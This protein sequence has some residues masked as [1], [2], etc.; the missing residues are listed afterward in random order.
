[1]AL[2][3]AVTLDSNTITNNICRTTTPEP[4]E[5]REP[6]EDREPIEEEPIDGPETTE[7]PEPIEEPEANVEPEPID[8]PETTVTP[9]PV[10]T[11]DTTYVAVTL[12]PTGSTAMT[13]VSGMGAVLALA[14]FALFNKKK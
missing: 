8:E 4:I 3:G 11:Q 14:G 12:P 6:R 5:D 13:A 9:E 7:E 10:N 1:M 2:N